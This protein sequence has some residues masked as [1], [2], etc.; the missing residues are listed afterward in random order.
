MVNHFSQYTVLLLFTTSS[1]LVVMV[2][3]DRCKDDLLGDC[4]SDCN[5]KCVAAHPG[6]EGICG[7]SLGFRN[8][9]W[10]YYECPPLK[11]CQ[12]SFFIDRGCADNTKCDL[13][14]AAKYP[15]KGAEGTCGFRAT[16]KRWS[17]DCTYF[18][19]PN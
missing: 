2:D 18:C 17:C 11:K 16:L 4:T 13:A 14:C 12:D 8:R 5:Q 7:P 9:C 10:C 3:G 15:G 19:N 1:I 6:G